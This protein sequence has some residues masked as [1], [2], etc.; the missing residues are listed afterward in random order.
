[1]KTSQD[2]FTDLENF[3]LQKTTH[4]KSKEGHGHK[5]KYK[6]WVEGKLNGGGA[7]VTMETRNGNIYIRKG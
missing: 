3:A 7:E 2:I 6:D 5:V 1:M 4:Q